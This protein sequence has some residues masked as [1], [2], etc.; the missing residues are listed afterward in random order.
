MR[1]PGRPQ[2]TT[3]CSDLCIFFALHLPPRRRYVR[4]NVRRLEQSMTPLRP[5]EGTD[6]EFLKEI[7]EAFFWDEAANRP[8]FASFATRRNQHRNAQSLTVRATS[9]T[10]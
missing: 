7:F 8:S 9:Y 3:L 1:Q 2:E 10:L 4:R 6:L 5:S